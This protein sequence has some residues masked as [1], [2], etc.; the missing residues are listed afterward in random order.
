MTQQ[1]RI[2]AAPDPEPEA[3]RATVPS[4]YDPQLEA[5]IRRHEA[6]ARPPAPA[7]PEPRPNASRK[8]YGY[9]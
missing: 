7:R 8:P 3:L 1:R 5:L 9:D 2:P 4:V 6:E